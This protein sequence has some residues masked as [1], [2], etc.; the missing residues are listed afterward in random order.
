VY[1]YSHLSENIAPFLKGMGE[2]IASRRKNL[3]MSQ[4]QLSTRAGIDRAYLSHLETGR[5]NPSIEVLM[6]VAAGLKLKPSRLLALC[7][8]ATVPEDPHML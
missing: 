4:K 1:A 3:G 5:T 8:R 7:E 6:K 2:V